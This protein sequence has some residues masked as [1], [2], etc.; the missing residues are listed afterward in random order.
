[1]ARVAFALQPV[2]WR[3]EVGGPLVVAR[4]A[5]PTSMEVAVVVGLGLAEEGAMAVQAGLLE[6]GGGRPG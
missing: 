3:G 6:V 2:L 4:R 1:V 5:G